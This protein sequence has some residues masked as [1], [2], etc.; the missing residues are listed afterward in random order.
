MLIEL[1]LITSKLQ[2]ALLK[3]SLRKLVTNSTTLF[4]FAN[5]NW[6][7]FYLNY[8]EYCDMCTPGSK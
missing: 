8:S 4:C 7:L 1:F 6:G 2:E 5:K 3:K